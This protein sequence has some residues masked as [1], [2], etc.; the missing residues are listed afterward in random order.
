M[1]SKTRQCTKAKYWDGLELHRIMFSIVV[2]R[3][4]TRTKGDDDDDDTRK[5]RCL[6]YLFV[7]KEV[8]VTDSG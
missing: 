6:S 3:T 5:K 7:L 1:N 2:T 8:E 4:T